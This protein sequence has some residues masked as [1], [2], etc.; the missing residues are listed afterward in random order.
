MKIN[1][2]EQCYPCNRTKDNF[3]NEDKHD[4]LTYHSLYPGPD[5]GKVVGAELHATGDSGAPQ[6]L[7]DDA[8][9]IH[10]CAELLDEQHEQV[11]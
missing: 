8:V 7:E 5:I 10:H 9:S 3:L 2:L 6:L 4:E 1:I 11:G